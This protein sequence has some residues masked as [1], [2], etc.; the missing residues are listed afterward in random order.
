MFAFAPLSTMVCAPALR[1]KV[2]DRTSEP[3]ES[4]LAGRLGLARTVEPSLTCNAAAVV[5]GLQPKM[6]M[7]YLPLF[8]AVRLN[9]SVPAVPRAADL[10]SDGTHLAPS[11]IGVTIAEVASG[12]P[13]EITGVAYFEPFGVISTPSGIRSIPAKFWYPHD[14][15]ILIVLCPTLNCNFA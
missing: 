8:G 15:V 5:P 11:P 12:A 1:S 7:R 14:G 13:R 2:E 10:N 6:R 3:V 4:A 9:V